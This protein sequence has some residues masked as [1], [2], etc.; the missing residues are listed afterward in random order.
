MSGLLQKVACVLRQLLLLLFAVVAHVALTTAYHAAGDHTPVV[1][2]AVLDLPA[3]P[4][5]AALVAADTA[6]V[7]SF[8]HTAAGMTAGR[9]P[10]AGMGLRNGLSTAVRAL[11]PPDTTPCTAQARLAMPAAAVAAAAA[12]SGPVK[13]RLLGGQVNKRAI[14]LLWRG[15][16]PS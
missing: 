8:V 1:V 9:R 16:P 2:P 7:H 14:T 10:A 15:F 6:A 13:G 3:V 12:P 5:A 11:L 4:A